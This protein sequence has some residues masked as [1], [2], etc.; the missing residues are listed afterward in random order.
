MNGQ[1]QANIN[2]KK[3]TVLGILLQ[4]SMKR[5]V[6]THGRNAGTAP[7]LSRLSKN[8]R[9]ASRNFGLNRIM[10]IKYTTDKLFDII[11]KN[12]PFAYAKEA[13]AEGVDVDRR[14]LS[15]GT[16]LEVATASGRLDI[17][18]ELCRVH[19][20]PS[21]TL[22]KALSIAASNNRKNIVQFFLDHGVRPEYAL[23]H[24]Y[25]YNS[26]GGGGSSISIYRMLA[27]RMDVR[28]TV[29][30][31][32]LVKAAKYRDG[33][34]MDILL[35][36][37]VNIDARDKDG[38]T[39][40]IQLQYDDTT[41]D[42]Q[43]TE[44]LAQKGASLDLKNNRGCTAIEVAL[45]RQKTPLVRKLS[46]LGARMTLEDFRMAMFQT[47]QYPNSQIRSF[48][49]NNMP[50]VQLKEKLTSGTS[51]LFFAIHTRRDSLLVKMLLDRG[52]RLTYP[53]SKLKIPVNNKLVRNVLG[54][55]VIEKTDRRASKRQKI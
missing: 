17:V 51:M 29:G 36:A 39:P 40:L 21:D 38:N 10:R 8:V 22:E 33:D 46:A 4:H 41:F 47:D 6:E 18:K 15:R 11:G 54:R 48:L 19:H 14:M 43:P 13:I 5:A 12:M 24:S 20:F 52:A 37:G 26:T 55:Y 25:G 7:V 34:Y 27:A 50:G 49:V 53:E 42:Y 1:V 30:R 28:G 31:E 35:N 32:A 23:L 2:A 16:V 45:R 44:L 9:Q 3:K